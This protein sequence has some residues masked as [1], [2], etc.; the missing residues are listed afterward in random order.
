M[1]KDEIP[2]V[3]IVMATYNGEKYIREQIESILN[4]DYANIEVIIVDDSS[5]DGTVIIL[6]E[7]KNRDSR[8]S[9][10]L[11]S[12]NK[13]VVATFEFG[14]SCAQGEFIALSDQDDIFDRRKISIMANEMQKNPTFDMV[15]SDP[16]LIDGN[17]NVIAYSMWKYQKLH[18]CGGKPFR[19]L[20]YANFGTGCACMLN[21]RLL[22]IAF[23][24]P[25]D[26]IVHDWWLTVVATSEK[27]G[28]ILIIDEQLMSYR[29]HGSNVIGASS[30]AFRAVMARLPDLSK[31]NIT[32][33][34]NLARIN[35]YLTRCDL[36][37]DKELRVLRKAVSLFEEFLKD[38]KTTFAKRVGNLINRIY[39][40]KNQKLTHIIGVIVFTLFPSLIDRINKLKPT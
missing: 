36:W 32:H 40:A 2:L 16:R 24:F 29:Q 20:L 10:H 25:T 19:Q 35:G 28:G 34:I 22:K 27:G 38:E 3:S 8:I 37:N 39:F 9:L 6:E 18:P 13:G 4:Q 11:S 23:P 17:G 1:D 31:R 14:L 33:A 12:I 26:S 7:Y 21:K 15:V 5:T 30:G